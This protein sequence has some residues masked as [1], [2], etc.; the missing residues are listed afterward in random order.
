VLVP[1]GNR[2]RIAGYYTLCA[3]SIPIGNLPDELIKQLRLPHYDRIPAT[4]IA[5][6][7]R[8]VSYKG[9]GVGNFCW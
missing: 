3:D 5:R 7:A 6:A 8:D 4:L 9:Q 1:A 2:S